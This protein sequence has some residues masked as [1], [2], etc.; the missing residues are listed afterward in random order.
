MISKLN[1]LLFFPTNRDPNSV[2]RTFGSCQ[3]EPVQVR[4]HV[5][6]Q[7]HTGTKK[8]ETKSVAKHGNSEHQ[9][10]FDAGERLGAAEKSS[11]SRGV[12]EG[13]D[14]KTTFRPAI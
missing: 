5:P 2:K 4:N 10:T 1:P 7:T 9:T 11:T 13:E 8:H 14:R 6:I 12:V 3:K